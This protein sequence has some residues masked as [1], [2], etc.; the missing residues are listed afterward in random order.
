MKPRGLGRVFKRGNVWWVEYWFR[1]EQHRESSHSTTPGAAVKLLKRRQGEMG[2]GRLIGPDAERLTFKD[3]ARMI[4]EDYQLND[5]RSRPP[6]MRLR[7]FFRPH[8]RALDITPDAVTRYIQHR[9]AEGAAAATIK[10]EVAALGRA[11]TLAYRAG[12]LPQRPPLPTV[13]VNNARSGFFTGAEVKELLKY[14][15]DYLR[16]FVEVAYITGW[17]RGELRSLRWAQVDWESGT[18]RLERGTTKSGEPRSFPFTAHPR[19]A[20]LLRELREKT[21][22]SERASGSVC[23][24]VFNR[25]GRHM[26]G[27]YYDSW[28]TACR[29]AGVPGRLFHD[30][31]RSAVRNLVRAGVSEQVAM[32]I[33]GHKTRSV[34]D[35]YHI[36][37]SADQVEAVRKLALLQGVV[38]PEPRR[39]VH[40]GDVLEERTRTVPAQLGH[41][42]RPS[43][44]QL[45]AGQRWA[46][47]SPTGFEPVS[48]P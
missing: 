2:R 45:A 25:A 32:S 40:L 38:T 24:W 28:R 5:R 30:L 29:K 26:R 13:R 14:L 6:L 3:L 44:T 22:A 11:F 43:R 35:R 4:V 1:G 37:S 17:R 31:R 48:P 42:G 27:W 10:N 9:Q 20:A 41:S 19:L 7:S 16:S 8:A 23:P 34:F 33:T 46:V 15:P 18:I 12:H 47:A 36:V 21:S 39:V